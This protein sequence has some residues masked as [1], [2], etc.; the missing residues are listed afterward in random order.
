MR[1]ARASGASSMGR[2]PLSRDSFQLVSRL[3]ANRCC[4]LIGSAVSW[5]VEEVAS[6]FGK[7]AAV[8]RVPVVTHRLGAELRHDAIRRLRVDLAGHAS[9][10]SGIWR[11]GAGQPHRQAQHEPVWQR[12][13]RDE[14]ASRLR[15]DC[16][17]GQE[18]AHPVGREGDDFRCDG[19]ATGV[20]HDRESLPRC[21]IQGRGGVFRERSAITTGSRS[22][23]RP[24]RCGQFFAHLVPDPDGKTGAAQQQDGFSRLCHAPILEVLGV[25]VMAPFMHE[26]HRPALRDPRRSPPC[27]SPRPHCRTA[28][29]R[30]RD[31]CPHRQARHLRS[32]TG[33]VPSL[34]THGPDRRIRRR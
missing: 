17:D 5:L 8:R 14:A 19:P 16:R 33:R 4:S 29:H 1:R 34:G 2:C 10:D 27:R 18:R 7:T 24:V 21:R 30:I 11:S 22:D 9:P 3:R 15:H 32:A 20:R 26:P 13:R 28:R 31:Q 23:H 6:T 25:T 12:H